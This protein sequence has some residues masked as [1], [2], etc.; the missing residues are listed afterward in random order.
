MNKEVV[1]KVSIK[2]GENPNWNPIYDSIQV[3]PDDEGGGSFLKI[4]GE[5]QL[6]E[7][8]SLSLNW[9]EWDT[10]VMVVENY[11]KDWEWG[12]DKKW[13]YEK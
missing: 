2:S 10:L 4:V 7:G 12:H 13:K 8:A 6:N 3:G 11:R 5:D 1:T 9:E